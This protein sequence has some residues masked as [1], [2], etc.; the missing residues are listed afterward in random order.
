MRRGALLD[1]LYDYSPICYLCYSYRFAAA[2]QAIW[3]L[4]IER[5]NPRAFT[6]MV[7]LRSF[8]GQ[9]SFD[10][11]FACNVDLGER[12][13]GGNLQLPFENGKKKK[14]DFRN[15]IT[16]LHHGT[17]STHVGLAA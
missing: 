9:C 8:R 10:G 2:D 1:T 11:A 12:E 6:M 17:H 4:D 7:T 15:R 5:T 3:D 14:R 13:E 16:Y